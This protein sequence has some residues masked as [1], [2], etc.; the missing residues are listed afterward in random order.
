[1]QVI[2]TTLFTPGSK[3]GPKLIP[4]NT[5]ALCYTL[6]DYSKLKANQ[7]DFAWLLLRMEL[8]ESL[9]QGQD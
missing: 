9:F 7:L 4:I 3:I 6:E 1:M 2:E 5:E 8:H